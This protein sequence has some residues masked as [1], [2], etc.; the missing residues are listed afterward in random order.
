M[1]DLKA[2]RKGNGLSQKEVA[3][4]LGVTRSFIGQVEAGFSKLPID[5][6]SKLLNNTH[7]WVTTSLVSPE[8]TS[9]DRIEQNGGKGNIG[10]IAGDSSAEL[11]ALRKENELLRQQLEEVKSQ[12]E[13][14]WVALM[15]LMK[16]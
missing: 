7:N 3:E 11:L 13:K 8:Q 9:G 10:K 6:V 16:K 2:F 1:V 12:N 14:Y 5:K 4:Y 15:E